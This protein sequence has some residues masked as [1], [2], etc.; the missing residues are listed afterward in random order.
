MKMWADVMSVEEVINVIKVWLITLEKHG[1]GK[2]MES[3]VF[4]IIFIHWAKYLT[5]VFAECAFDK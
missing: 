1:C 4:T 3:G 5:R 2:M